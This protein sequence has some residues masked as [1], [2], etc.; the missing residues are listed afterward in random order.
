MLYPFCSKYSTVYNRA[1]MN[2]VYSRTT[3]NVPFAIPNPTCSD[4]Y[5]QYTT[6]DRSYWPLFF[7]QIPPQLPSSLIF[8]KNVPPYFFAIIT[9][10]M[11][12]RHA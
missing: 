6:P 10:N 2:V 1:I 7:V 9:M 12:S 8:P 5:V 4:F 3:F 11:F